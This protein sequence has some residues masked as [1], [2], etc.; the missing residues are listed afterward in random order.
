MQCGKQVQ[1]FQRN[2]GI[3]LPDYT[4]HSQN[5][6]YH[7]IILLNT[8]PKKRWKKSTHAH[9]HVCKCTH[10]HKHEATGSRK[11]IVIHKSTSRLG[12]NDSSIS[13]E[14]YFGQST[15]S[16]MLNHFFLPV[17]KFW[18]VI[19]VLVK[20][21]ERRGQGHTSASLLHLCAT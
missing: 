14:T 11:I 5:F 1:Q 19:V 18:T 6:K 4:H 10:P 20:K 2:V 12:P 8:Q 7:L 16:Q 9:P 17:Q 3:Y 15:F 21:D 13:T